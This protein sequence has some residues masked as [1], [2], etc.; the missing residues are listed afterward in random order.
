MA[1]A[2]VIPAL[3]FLTALMAGPSPA[4]AG[5][6]YPWHSEPIAA[7]DTLSG[8]IQPPA[9]F[10]RLEAAPESFAAWLR[11][12]PLRPAGS[13][14]TLY[15]GLPK[16]WRQV[17][18]AVIDIDVGTRDLQQCADAVMRLR[19]E[20]LLARG[21]TA[22]IA[23]NY[24]N[25]GRVDFVRWSRGLRPSPSKKGV[26]WAKAAKADASYPSFKRYLENVFTYAGTTSL[27]REL[28]SVEMSDLKIGDV[29]IVG[30]FPGHAVLVADVA[31]NPATG[32]TR[33]LLAQSFMP[34]QD[35]HVLKNPA[36]ADGSP[37][38]PLDFGSELV[39]PEW[40]FGRDSLKRWREE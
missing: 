3:L 19:A 26:T 28:R 31:R 22:E 9:G 20:W 24:T 1:A 37:W 13:T 15:N 34:A 35:I 39:T 6:P 5:G 18:V 36:S 33:F 4:D 40:T 23:F 2:R 16:F 32:D 17:H 25:D 30:G 11:G 29:I 38:Y 8:R 21:R 14:V 27:A 12:L 10:R 7:A